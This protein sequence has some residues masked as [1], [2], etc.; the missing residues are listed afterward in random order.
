MHWA[1][2]NLAEHAKR[3]I[4]S[5]QQWWCP[6]WGRH[7]GGRRERGRSLA[8]AIVAFT[9]AMTQAIDWLSTAVY[10]DVVKQLTVWHNQGKRRHDVGGRVATSPVQVGTVRLVL[11]FPPL[12]FSHLW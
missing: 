11:S 2:N 10:Y 9:E 1:R 5:D 12:I 6:I 7:A 4:Y 8:R 3:S